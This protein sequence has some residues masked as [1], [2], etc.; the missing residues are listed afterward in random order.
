MFFGLVQPWLLKVLLDDVLVNKK[1]DLFFPVIAASLLAYFGS[2][3]LMI[4]RALRATKLQQAVQRDIARRLYR[5]VESLDMNDAKSKKVGDLMSRI[6]VDVSTVAGVPAILVDTFTRD[7]VQ[8]GTVLGI[9]LLLSAEVTVLALAIVPVYI[10][11]ER[12]WARLMKQKTSGVRVKTADLFS[13]LQETLSS[14]K[15]IKIFGREEYESEVLDE[16]V[17][18]A[19]RERYSSQLIAMLAAFIGGFLVYLPSFIVLAVGGLQVLAGAMTIGVLVAL[20]S[21]VGQL[22]GPLVSF[23][24]LNRT[25]QTSSV[26]MERVFEIVDTKPKIADVPDAINIPSVKGEL[27][28]RNVSFEYDEGRRVIDKL[29]AKINPGARI[30]I[31][32]PTGVGKSTLAALLCRL[33]DPTEGQI[34]LDG[35][36]LRKISLESLRSH[37]GY[38]SQES[39]LFNATVR[40]NIRFGRLDATDEDVER[41]ARLAQAHEFIAKLPESYDTVVGERGSRLSG[42]EQQRIALARVILRNPSVIVFDEPTS[43]LDAESE[44]KLQEA[45][46]EVTQ[47]KTTVVIAHRL[48]TLRN[49]DEIWVLS[50]TIV[51]KGTFEELVRKR[52]LFWKYYNTQFG[53]FQ[54][55]LQKLGEEMAR[56]RKYRKPIS[57]LGMQIE[58]YDKHEKDSQEAREF[59]GKVG[60]ALSASIEESDFSAEYPRRRGTFIVALPGTSLKEARKAG[61]VLARSMESRFDIK[62][63]TSVTQLKPGVLTAKD[64]IAMCV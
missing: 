56:A 34:F 21:Y 64:F 50:G 17:S 59:L 32:G 47:G 35:V 6:D 11:S 58:D 44:A 48:S 52:G 5:H 42:G 37:I 61:R 9:A 49:A 26:G 24:N 22:L 60:A 29:S 54:S 38:L 15:T 41:A 7:V 20:Q 40:E 39:V 46:D 1:F 2:N 36:D 27:E 53:G 19:N 23:A 4:T 45:L 13:F 8:L 55:F 62:L 51:E 43:A 30:G 31:V 3:T 63:A 10:M 16:K 12:K 14:L 18:A 33:Y 28:F 25:L 57:L